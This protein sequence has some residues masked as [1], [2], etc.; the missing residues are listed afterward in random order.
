MP[1]P[2]PPPPGYDAHAQRLV[3]AA[4]DATPNSQL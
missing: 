4:Q 1:A 2:E 3:E